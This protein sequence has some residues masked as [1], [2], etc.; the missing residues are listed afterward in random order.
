MKL[1]LGQALEAI[2]RGETAEQ[3]KRRRARLTKLTIE[4]DC[5]ED[6]LEILI[7]PEDAPRAEQKKKRLQKVQAEIERLK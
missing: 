5:L 6:A 2:S 1:T 3:Y 4:R 7:L